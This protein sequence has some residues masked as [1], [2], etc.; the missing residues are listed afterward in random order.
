MRHLWIISIFSW[1]TRY[2]IAYWNHKQ[3]KIYTKQWNAAQV[4]VKITKVEVGNR[5]IDAQIRGIEKLRMNNPEQVKLYL[6]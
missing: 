6:Y 2:S 4:E 3:S 5:N 1:I